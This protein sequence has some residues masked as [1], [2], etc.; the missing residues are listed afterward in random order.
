MIIDSSVVINT[1]QETDYK[2]KKKD[3]TEDIKPVEDSNNGKR[4]ELDFNKDRIEDNQ[5]ETMARDT[6]A[7]Y[8]NKGEIQYE[9]LN[10]KPPGSEGDN[11]DIIV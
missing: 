2:I 9:R 5:T 10:S 3:E 1:P 11:I 6:G 8:G 7:I 4:A